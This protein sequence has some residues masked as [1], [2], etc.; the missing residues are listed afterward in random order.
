MEGTLCEN[1]VEVD[2][3]LIE[4]T[5]IIEQVKKLMPEERYIRG[6]SFQK[7]DY[8]RLKE[9]TNKAL[10]KLLNHMIAIN[11]TQTSRLTKAAVT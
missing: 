8:F 7:T 4:Q 9:L 3:A 10:N 5:E 11:I 6:I 1:V 2:D